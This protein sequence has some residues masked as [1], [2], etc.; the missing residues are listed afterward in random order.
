MT[1]ILGWII[2]ITLL[3]LKNT[4][5]RGE[6]SLRPTSATPPQAPDTHPPHLTPTTHPLYGG[7][8]GWVKPH[9]HSPPLP[10]EKKHTYSL[11]CTA[12]QCVFFC[13]PTSCLLS[14]GSRLRLS[15]R[16]SHHASVSLPLSPWR[17]TV[18]VRF[19]SVCVCRTCCFRIVRSRRK[20][21]FLSCLT[22][23]SYYVTLS[24]WMLYVTMV[25]KQHDSFCANTNI[26]MYIYRVYV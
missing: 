24:A 17:R 1:G 16:L 20:T 14:H 23:T 7:L 8:S 10:K 18:C 4:R 12:L 21:G 9:T 3:L 22:A 13:L 6:S 26:N 5:S 15:S 25:K 2:R 19:V 11:I